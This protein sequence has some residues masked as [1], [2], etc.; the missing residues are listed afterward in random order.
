VLIPTFFVSV[1]LSTLNPIP[2]DAAER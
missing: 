2:F 1:A